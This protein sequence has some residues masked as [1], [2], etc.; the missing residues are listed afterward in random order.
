MKFLIGSS[1]F[2]SGYED[3]IP[4]DVDELEIVETETFNHKRQIT[5]MGRCLF[6]LKKKDHYS[7]YLDWDV[8]TQE[9]MAVG[10]WLVPEFCEAVG[11]TIENLHLLQ[12]LIDK[13]DEKH[14]YEKIIYDSYKVNNDFK[15]TPEQ[16][17]HAYESYK[18]SRAG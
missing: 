6:Q 17:A 16:R 8:H 13:L 1:Y 7:E 10:K 15:L 9:G 3:F 14:M 11:F 12:P 4:K 5:G 18:Q 2:F